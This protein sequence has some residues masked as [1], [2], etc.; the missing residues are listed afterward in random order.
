MP[1]VAHCPLPALGTDSTRDDTVK[2][3]VGNKIDRKEERVVSA[4]E[5]RA[6]ARANSMLFLECSAR[7]EQG[8]QQVFDE[9][10][11]KILDA[12]SLMEEA[13]LASGGAKVSVDD[14]GYDEQAPALCPC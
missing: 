12:P 6:F 11:Q 9:L 13:G 5:A 1:C 8:I 10:I 14:G 3:L 7:T 4:D 2:L